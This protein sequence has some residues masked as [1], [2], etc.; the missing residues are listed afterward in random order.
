MR[1][2][3]YMIGNSDSDV[4]FIAADL[5]TCVFPSS[6]HLKQK[7]NACRGIYEGVGIFEV[8]FATCFICIYVG[9]ID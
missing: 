1:H 8:I 9:I 2:T 5:S 4:L 3:D 6:G 7:D